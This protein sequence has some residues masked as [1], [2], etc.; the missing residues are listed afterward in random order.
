MYGAARWDSRGRQAP[1]WKQVCAPHLSTRSLSAETRL[2][3][4]AHHVTCRKR[5]S[6]VMPSSGT[7]QPTWLPKL[8]I[9][10]KDLRDINQLW[11][12]RNTRA[13]AETA[14]KQT[15]PTYVGTSKVVKT[16]YP[17]RSPLSWRPVA[18]PRLLTR[19]APPS[20]SS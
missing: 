2:A 1:A 6:R 19:C 14:T 16:D 4:R 7:N 17:V 8:P 5:A 12:E 11:G 9:I 13:M 10:T 15:G 3:P 18:R 20:T